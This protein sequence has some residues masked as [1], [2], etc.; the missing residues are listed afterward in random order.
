MFMIFFYLAEHDNSAYGLENLLF[1]LGFC[2]F[3]RDDALEVLAV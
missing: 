1:V 3:R 2:T